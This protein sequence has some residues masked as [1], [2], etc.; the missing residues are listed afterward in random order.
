M[1]KESLKQNILFL[2]GVFDSL[3]EL[4][5]A[6]AAHRIVNE[7]EVTGEPEF[8]SKLFSKRDPIGL[9]SEQSAIKIQNLERLK[10]CCTTISD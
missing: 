4:E 10:K 8:Y 1:E 2:E 3:I 9:D 7:A 5:L 6:G